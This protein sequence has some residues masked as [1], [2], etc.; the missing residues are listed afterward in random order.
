[1]RPDLVELLHLL[2]HE[3]RSPSG[4]LQ[5]Y[6]RM[7]HEG[8]LT[9]EADRAQAYEN[10]RSASA[11]IA[12]LGEETARLAYWLEP[13]DRKPALVNAR[14][15]VQRAVISAAVNPPVEV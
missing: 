4:V 11:R 7:L 1:M 10:M 14:E 6:L 8:R 5:G 15:L 13:A 2:A 3:V 12:A 9:S